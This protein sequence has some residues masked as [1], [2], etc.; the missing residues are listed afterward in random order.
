M[1]RVLLSAVAVMLAVAI[2][3]GDAAAQRRVIPYFGGGLAAGTG[4]LGTDTD[5]G[6]LAFAG[7]DFPLGLNPGLTFGV[8]ATYAHVP[9]Q[10]EFDEATNIPAFVGELGYVIGANS[11]SIVKPY[12]RAGLG[13]QLRKYDPGTTGFREQSDGGL[14]FS[15]GGGLQFLVSTA[16][17]FVGAHY[18]GDA[19]AGFLAFHAGIGFPGRARAGAR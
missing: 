10:S 4:D 3:S 1:K 18:V 13:V 15:G 7:L 14:A 5:N 11:S 6:W 12:L 9:F 19:D 2:P 17:V 16:S 8:T